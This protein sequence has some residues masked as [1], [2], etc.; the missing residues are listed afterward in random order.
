MP[1]P[2]PAPF[3]GPG[4]FWYRVDQGRG[5]HRIRFGGDVDLLSILRKTDLH[6]GTN[7]KVILQVGRNATFQDMVLQILFPTE[8]WSEAEAHAW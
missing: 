3:E 2:L 7:S 4:S 6:S 5:Y 8:E 1:L